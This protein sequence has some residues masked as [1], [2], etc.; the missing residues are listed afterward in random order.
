MGEP[1]VDGSFEK[2]NLEEIEQRLIRLKTAKP[3]TFLEAA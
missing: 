2:K 1:Y 3:S